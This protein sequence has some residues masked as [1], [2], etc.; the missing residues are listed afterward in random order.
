MDLWGTT[1]DST[2]E[3]LVFVLLLITWLVVILCGVVTGLKGRVGWLLVGFLLGG[4]PWL[5]SAW[6]PATPASLWARRRPLDGRSG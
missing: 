5:V 1:S 4:V 3:S 2:V 6:L